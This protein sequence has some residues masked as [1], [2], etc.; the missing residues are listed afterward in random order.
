MAYNETVKDK[1]LKSELQ[2]QKIKADDKKYI[3]EQIIS[4]WSLKFVYSGNLSTSTSPL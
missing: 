2:E 3:G 4:D 1:Q